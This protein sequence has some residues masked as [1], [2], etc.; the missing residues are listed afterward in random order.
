MASL[1]V[2]V[3]ILWL[4]NLPPRATYAPLRKYGFLIAGLIK[5]KDQWLT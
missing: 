5:G 3:Y 2:I 1:I 4:V